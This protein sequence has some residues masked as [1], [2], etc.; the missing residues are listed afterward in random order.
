M[1]R[2]SVSALLL[3][4]TL[5]L[6]GKTATGQPKQIWLDVQKAQTAF[7]ELR[8]MCK[9]DGGKLW[10]KSICGAVMFVDPTS[11]VLIA[12]ARPGDGSSSTVAGLFVSLLP[13]NQ[14]ISNTSIQWDGI[15]W[16]QVI[17]PLPADA[18][19]RRVLLAHESFHRLQAEL[20]LPAAIPDGNAHL[21]TLKGRLWL[22][23]EWRALAR[24]IKTTGAARKVAIQDALA[25]RAARH[26]EFPNAMKEERQLELGEGLAQYTGVKLAATS[27]REL[28]SLALSELD[29]GP[30]RPS[31]TRSFAYASAPAYGMLLDEAGATWRSIVMSSF[32]LGDKLRRAF[33]VPAPSVEPQA[34]DAR[35]TEYDGVELRRAEEARES[36]RIVRI[37]ELRRTLVDGPVLRL[38][39]I[40]PNLQFDPRTLVPLGPKQTVYPKVQL[41]DAWGTL[42]VKGAVLVDWESGVATVTAPSSRTEPLST[43]D[44]S[45]ALDQAWTVEPDQRQGDLRLRKR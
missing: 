38:P 18:G 34:L 22:Q 33:D 39:L 45:L 4:L 26:N 3:V 11:R 35:A 17:W 29:T 27:A 12:N 42:D 1:A 7:D 21:D 10:G 24:A 25:F 31:F 8:T 32:D 44:W 37:A 28:K 14:T 40:R 9:R 2:T 41:I 23:L 43:P 30:K 13:S 20:G 6:P 15:R 19:A 16:S 5:M 36:E